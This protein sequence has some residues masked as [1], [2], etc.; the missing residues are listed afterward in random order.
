MVALTDVYGKRRSSLSDISM[1][2]VSDFFVVIKKDR[3]IKRYQSTTLDNLNGP[4]YMKLIISR[5]L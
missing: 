1:L 5:C 2:R 3:I 4:T